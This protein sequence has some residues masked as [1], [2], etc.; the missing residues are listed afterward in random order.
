MFADRV[1]RTLES[2][3]RNALAIALAPALGPKTLLV[4]DTL[5]IRRL[6]V[7]RPLDLFT[8]AAFLREHGVRSI[9]PMSIHAASIQSR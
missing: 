1:L 2:E 3:A 7:A 6:S 4:D 8:G 9:S 5:F